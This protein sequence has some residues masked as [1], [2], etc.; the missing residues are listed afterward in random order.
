M[1]LSTTI[2]AL[3]VT[4]MAAAVDFYADRFRFTAL[5]HDEEFAVLRRDDAI[6]HLWGASDTGWRLRATA[7]LQETPVRTGAEDFLAG[8][9]SCRIHVDDVDALYAELAPAEV[10]HP[11]D[12]GAPVDTDWGTR[13]F[14]TLDLAGNLLTFFQRT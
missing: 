12:R 3:P 2:P 8:T 10:L 6:V 11:T 7:D 14:A 1:R 13:E 4:D 5:H 9:A